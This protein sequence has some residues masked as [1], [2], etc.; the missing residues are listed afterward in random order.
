LIAVFANLKAGTY[1]I[2]TFHDRNSNDTVDK[3]LFG[4]PTEKYGFSRDAAG[5]MGPPSFEAAA[6]T[7]GSDDHAI[8]INLR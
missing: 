4:L 6:F 7:V 2:S 1:A 8:V 3:N 5:R